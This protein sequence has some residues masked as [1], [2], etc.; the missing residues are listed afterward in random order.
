MNR[1]TFALL[2]LAAG[3]VLLIANHDAGEIFGV[4]SDDFADLVR[5]FSLAALIGAGV[6]I[7]RRHSFGRVARD[8]MAW[9]VIALG[10]IVLW[11]Y[12]GDFLALGDR[13]RAALVPGQAVVSRGADG[14]T[15][16][17]LHKSMSGHFEATVEING[18]AVPMLVDTGASAISLSWEDARRAGLNPEN[19]NYSATVM[20]ANGPA[21]AAPVRLAQV[22][23]GPVSRR[24]VLALVATEG[25]LERSLLG[26][27][28]LSTLSSIRMESDE[29]RLRD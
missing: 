8:L 19:L 24:N 15:E 2:I 18:R 13:V 16:I 14:T 5:L 28:F 11:L 10:L 27:S 9:A 25:R 21:S 4:G 7:G 17:I 22:S 1:Y 20:T 6:L 29:M 12:R 23:L 3:L 26:M